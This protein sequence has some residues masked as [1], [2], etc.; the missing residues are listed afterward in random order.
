VAAEL[1]QAHGV[2]AVLVE[3]KGGVFK[4]R[5]NGTLLYDKDEAGRFPAPGEAARLLR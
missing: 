5:R 1:K 3:G 2:D 4:I